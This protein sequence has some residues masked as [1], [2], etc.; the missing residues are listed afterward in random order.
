MPLFE[1]SDAIAIG[2]EQIDDDH[3]H[4]IGQINKLFA[5]ISSGQGDQVLGEVL[6]ELLRYVE[7]HF[8]REEALMQQ[9]DYPDYEWH[10]AA[11]DDLIT[12]VMEWRSQHDAGLMVSPMSVFCSLEEWLFHHIKVCDANLGVALRAAGRNDKP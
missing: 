3:K 9:I 10:K 6:D 4:L 7:A 8:Q 11:H 12:E 1:W 5:G 2:N